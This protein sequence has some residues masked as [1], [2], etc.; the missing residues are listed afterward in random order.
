MLKGYLKLLELNLILRIKL[1]FAFKTL[2]RIKIQ[3]IRKYKGQ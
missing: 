3:I 1:I 2:L